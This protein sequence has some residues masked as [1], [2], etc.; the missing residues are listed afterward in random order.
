M[1]PIRPTCW[2]SA[3]TG[4]TAPRVEGSGTG[5]AAREQQLDDD[6]PGWNVKKGFALP[7]IRCQIRPFELDDAADVYAAIQESQP[8][9]ARWMPDLNPTLTEED[10]RDWITGQELMSSGNMAYNFAIVD[11][12]SDRFLGGCGLTQINPLLRMANLY[13]WVR[14]SAAGNGAA[15]HAAR[16]LARYGFKTLGLLRIE[17]VVAL[18][19]TASQRVAQKSG[20]ACEGTMRN[21]ILVDGIPYPASMYSLIPSDFLGNQRE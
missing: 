8:E 20:A 3:P 10:I 19:N 12:E 16:L 1:K 6:L 13:Y 5:A 9:L 7:G 14:S 21:R 17:I 11:G 15:T 4:I 2:S 18:E